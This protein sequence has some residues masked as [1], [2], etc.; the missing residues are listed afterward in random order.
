[1]LLDVKG[2][3]LFG[4]CSRNVC[5][6]LALDDTHAA[7]ERATCAATSPWTSRPWSVQGCWM[8][9]RRG[10]WRECLK[11]IHLRLPHGKRIGVSS[12]RRRRSLVYTRAEP[13]HGLGMATRGNHRTR[14]SVRPT[15]GPCVAY[16]HKCGHGVKELVGY[17][18]LLDELFRGREGHL[19]RCRCHH[20]SRNYVAEGARR[21]T[22][23]Q[24]KGPRVWR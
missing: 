16:V 17:V 18:H 5:I 19:A 3:L 6:R 22:H 4:K 24:V 11:R 7:H 23:L 20:L 8:G 14:R 21:I 10:R 1:M 2:C 15:A 9:L 12:D 13:S